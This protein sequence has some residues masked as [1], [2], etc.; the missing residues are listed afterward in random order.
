MRFHSYP[1]PPKFPCDRLRSDT[2]SFLFCAPGNVQV[3]PRLRITFQ[4]EPHSNHISLYM[5]ACV[6][7]AVTNDTSVCIMYSYILFY[8][9]KYWGFTLNVIRSFRNRNKLVLTQSNLLLFP[10]F[11]YSDKSWSSFC[12]QCNACYITVCSSRTQNKIDKRTL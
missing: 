7:C 4:H 6:T 3:S 12:H 8:K 9:T 2:F 11:L 10:F 1:Q 5:R